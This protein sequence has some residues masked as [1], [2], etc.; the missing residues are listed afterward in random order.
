MVDE[1]HDSAYRPKEVSPF[2]NA[3]DSAQV[4][5]KFYH[6]NVILGS[7]TPSVESYYSAKND[8]L[9]YVFLGERYGNVKLPDFCL[10]YTSR[11]V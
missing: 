5:A 9:K 4:L 2:F 10:L 3:K 7:A 6:A 11:C 1:E 8:K